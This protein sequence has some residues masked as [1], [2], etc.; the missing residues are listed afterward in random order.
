MISSLAA[1]F[2]THPLVTVLRN[3]M[4]V[5]PTRAVTSDAMPDTLGGGP[6]TA[7]AADAAAGTDLSTCATRS[8]WTRALLLLVL[9]CCWRGAAAVG[10]AAAGSSTGEER[11]LLL[12]ATGALLP[13]WACSVVHKGVF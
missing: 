9:L 13:P 1:T 7:A 10:H 12:C 11:E 6:S 5:W 3:T 4:G 2:A 8:C